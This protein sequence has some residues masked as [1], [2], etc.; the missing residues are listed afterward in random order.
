MNRKEVAARGIGYGRVST[1]FVGWISQL[2]LTELPPDV[3]IDTFM[4]EAELVAS[5]IIDRLDIRALMKE[6]NITVT[7]LAQDAFYRAYGINRPEQIRVCELSDNDSL[8]AI[9]AE[10]VIYKTEFN[11]EVELL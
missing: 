1:A 10:T 8:R 6:R 2:I 11:E 5:N 3:T 9:A 7:D 4:E